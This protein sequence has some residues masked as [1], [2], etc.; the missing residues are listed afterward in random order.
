MWAFLVKVEVGFNFYSSSFSSGEK[1]CLCPISFQMKIHTCSK[2]NEQFISHPF[3]LITD[4]ETQKWTLRCISSGFCHFTSFQPSPATALTNKIEITANSKTP[5]WKDQHFMNPSRISIYNPR[6]HNENQEQE[7]NILITKLK[8][9]VEE[10]TK[11][12]NTYVKCTQCSRG[13]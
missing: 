8:E 6:Y 12:K 9:G 1:I 4:S 5:L 3:D 10:N 7:K 11:I 13:I 2:S